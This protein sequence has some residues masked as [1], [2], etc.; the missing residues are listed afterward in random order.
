MEEGGAEVKS[1][2]ILFSKEEKSYILLF[3]IERK[4]SQRKGSMFAD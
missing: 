2:F 3:R 4:L 1:L